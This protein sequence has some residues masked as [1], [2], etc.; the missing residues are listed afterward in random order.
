MNY[1]NKKD[2]PNEEESDEYDKY[3]TNFYAYDSEEKKVVGAIRLV[4]DSPLKFPLEKL[5]DISWLHSNKNK[6]IA[7]VSRRVTSPLSRPM[8][9]YGLIAIINQ[10]SLKNGI[11]DYI[12]AVP[13]KDTDFSKK[14]GFTIF[15]D[16]K[17]Y[18][19]LNNAP[20]VLVHIK[21]KNFK[22]PN[23]SR[24]LAYPNIF[25]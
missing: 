11:T 5:F 9:N 14:L 7:E 18:N 1:I 25:L 8:T 23:K 6:K 21:I 13:P 17:Y 15:N 22:E 3:S 10:Y 12:A 16:I 2:Y 4:H 24:L 19:N 20:A